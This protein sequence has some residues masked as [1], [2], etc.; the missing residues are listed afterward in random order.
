MRSTLF[1]NQVGYN[2]FCIL[3]VGF[4]YKYE[5]FVLA[6]ALSWAAGMMV[7]LYLAYAVAS[8]YAS[9]M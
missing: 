5:T 9:F 3:S 7:N 6:R 2:T 8:K 1:H 4:S